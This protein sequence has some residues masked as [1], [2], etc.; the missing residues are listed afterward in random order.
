MV[1]IPYSARLLARAVVVAAVATHRK[2]R[3]ATMAA[4]V[5]VDRK[6]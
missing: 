1:T 4:L 3:P 2:A 6:A 5:V